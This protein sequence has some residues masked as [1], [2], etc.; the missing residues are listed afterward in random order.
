MFALAKFFGETTALQ[1]FLEPPQ[2]R[3]DGFPVMNAH[4]KGHNPSQKV[5]ESRQPTQA[6]GFRRSYQ[7]GAAE[8][9]A[10]AEPSPVP[11]TIYFGNG[12][13]IRQLAF[14]KS[15]RWKCPLHGIV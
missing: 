11:R 12:R 9:S 3:T 15:R 13:P 2:R 7:S 10:S 5:A 8:F 6:S 4:S 1:Q 14:N